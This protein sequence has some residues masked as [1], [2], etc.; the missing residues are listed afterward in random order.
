MMEEHTSKV[1]HSL[2]L[3]GKRTKIIVVL[4]IVMI[5]SIIVIGRIPVHRTKIEHLDLR[6]DVTDLDCDI[7]Q[8]R[9]YLIGNDIA[10]EMMVAGRI[11]ISSTYLYRLTIVAKGIDDDSAHI[12]ALTCKDG[13]VSQFDLSVSTENDTMTIFFPLTQF[14]SDSYM[15]GL[16]G[17]A[18]NVHETDYTMEDRNGTVARLLFW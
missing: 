14:I 4:V 2:M 9:S 13:T 11:N 1:Q 15:I 16:E 12:Y 7:I 17:T 5:P 18:T 10:L 3:L 8:I 6:G